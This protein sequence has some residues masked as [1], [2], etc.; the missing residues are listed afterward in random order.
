MI[1]D[2]EVDKI[3]STL[4]A[5][6]VSWSRILGIGGKCKQAERVRKNLISKN[7]P[8]APVYTLRKDHKVTIDKDVG[9]PV[10]PVCGVDS[11]GNEKLSW[12]LS[13]IFCKLWE[14]DSTGNVCLSTEELLAEIK[15]V[16]NAKTGSTSYSW[17]CRCKGI[18]P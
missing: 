3:E 6:A 15:A 17:F 9:P 10:R 11:A 2:T 16:N 8:L 1:S 18:I 13:S 5:H 4:S 12:L 7:S 14:G